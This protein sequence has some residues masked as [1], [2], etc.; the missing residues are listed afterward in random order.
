MSQNKSW[1][2]TKKEAYAVLKSVQRFVYYLRGA[3]YTLRCNHK[4][5]EPFLSRGMKITK[6]DRLLEEY[7]ITFTHV[8]GKENILTDAI[9]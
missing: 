1:H 7:D 2:A 5:L 9:S 8:R 3:K 6:M 4:P